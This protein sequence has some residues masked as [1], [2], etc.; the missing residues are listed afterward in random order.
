[1][2]EAITRLRTRLPWIAQRSRIA[3]RR[4]FR[5]STFQYAN[6]ATAQPGSMRASQILFAWHGGLLRD[7]GCDA[8]KGQFE[9][10]PALLSLR[11]CSIA[12]DA[13][14]S[15][16]SVQTVITSSTGISNIPLTRTIVTSPSGVPD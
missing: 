3:G 1:M 4:R 9:V 11:F 6:A 12:S 13:V 8:R 5:P 15:G 10:E 14:I 7:I 2:P 16:L